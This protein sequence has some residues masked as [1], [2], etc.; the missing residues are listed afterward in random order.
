MVNYHW[1]VFDQVLIRPS[2]VDNFD[3][4]SLKF[5]DFDGEKSLL[6]NNGTPNKDKYSDH[7]PLV[8]TLN[9]DLK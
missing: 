7:L 8:F 9:L 6:K 2:L 5:V 4:E 3:K 1:N